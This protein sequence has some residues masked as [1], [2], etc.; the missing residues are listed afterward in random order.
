MATSTVS[1]RALHAGVFPVVLT[2]TSTSTVSAGDTVL[3]GKIGHG[4]TILDGY[5]QTI[6]AANETNDLGVGIGA[7]LVLS[8]IHI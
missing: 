3:M 6:T 5:I 8:L 2:F 4:V 7:S 1:P